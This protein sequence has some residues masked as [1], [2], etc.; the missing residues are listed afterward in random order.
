MGMRDLVLLIP[1]FVVL[2]ARLARDPQVPT[3]LK[4]VAG[5]TLAY[6]ASPLD[7]LPEILLGPIGA[8]D[9]LIAISW[10]VSFLV[11]RLHPDLIRQH[12]PGSD[13]AID[14]I[15]RVTEWTERQITERLLG[16]VSRVLRLGR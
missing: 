4:W 7:L 15:E 14:A 11:N 2:L 3:G 16:A 8:I 13:D 5:S 10:G 12:W 9:D 6:V 1:D